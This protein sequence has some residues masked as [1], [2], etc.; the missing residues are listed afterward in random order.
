LKSLRHVIA[1]SGSLGRISKIF[2][3]VGVVSLILSV[4]VSSQILAFIGLGL[5]FWGVLFIF[6]TSTR[7]VEGSLLASTAIAEYITIDRILKEFRYTGKAYY[8]PPFPRDTPLPEYLK[9]LKETTVFLSAKNENMIPP[10]ERIAK[11]SFATKNP[12]GL[13]VAPPGI[14]LLSRIEKNLGVGSISSIGLI[15]GIEKQLEV[16]LTKITTEELCEILPKI[17]VENLNLA[18]EMG[19]QL[20]GNQIHLEI[21]GS[22]YQDLYSGDNNSISISL[23]GCPIT[24]AIASLIARITSKIVTIQKF[25]IKPETSVVNASYSFVDAVES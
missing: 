14:G 21:S 12:N 25:E 19:M 22:L 18:K 15:S 3:L 10:I 13:L 8:L 20:E 6:I 16:D 24:S 9:G 17:I 11:G 4:F 2:L 23:L 1:V 7:Y 5:T